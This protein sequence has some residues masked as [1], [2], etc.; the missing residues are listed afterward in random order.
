MMFCIYV[1]NAMIN[2]YLIGVF[3]DQFSIKNEK[4]MN[5]Q[6]ELDESNLTMSMLAIL[7]VPLK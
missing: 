1:V 7:P 5:K 2:A 4:K 3:I 6:E